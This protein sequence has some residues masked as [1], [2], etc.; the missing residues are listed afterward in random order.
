MGQVIASLPDQVEEKVLD[1]RLRRAEDAAVAK[2][3]REAG[4]RTE[5]GRDCPRI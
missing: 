5:R 4:A 3:A 2:W 1:A